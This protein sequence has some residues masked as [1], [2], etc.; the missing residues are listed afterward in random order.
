MRWLME[1]PAMALIRSLAALILAGLG[2]GIASRLLEKLLPDDWLPWVWLVMLFCLFA[3]FWWALG[4][5]IQ[6]SA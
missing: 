5:V 2:T 3:L 4:P 1:D 6:P